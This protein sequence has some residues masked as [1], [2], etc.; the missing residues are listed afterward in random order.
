M[1]SRPTSTPLAPE[2]G[3]QPAIEAFAVQGEGLGRS[4]GGLSTKIHLAVDGRGLPT[5]AIVTPGQAGDNP[6]LP[7][8]LDGIRVRRRWSRSAWSTGRTRC[9]AV[10]RVGPGHLRTRPDTVVADKAY[11]HPSTRRALR[12]RG[13]RFTCPER[14]DQIARRSAKGSRAGRPPALNAHQ[15]KQRNVVER[16]FNRLKQFRDLL[17]TTPNRQRTLPKWRNALTV[18][19]RRGHQRGRRT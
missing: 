14:A 18:K 9:P 7:S 1:W 17:P 13:F 16:R 4:P 11:P 5:R 2:R 3:C 8:L 10:S 6:Q 19:Q 12:E 15:Y